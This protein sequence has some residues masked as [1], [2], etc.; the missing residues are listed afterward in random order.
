VRFHGPDNDAD[1]VARNWQTGL[2][3]NHTVP[4]DI[5]PGVWPITGIWAHAGAN[6]HSSDFVPVSAAITVAP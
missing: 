4:I 1:Q 3:A 6:N 5:A 2:S